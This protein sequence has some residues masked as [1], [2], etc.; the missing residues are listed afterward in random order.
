MPQ[1]G[2]TYHQAG[3]FW[4]MAA[5]QTGQDVSDLAV[6]TRNGLVR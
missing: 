2:Q 5:P 3:R 1:E 4:I 6:K